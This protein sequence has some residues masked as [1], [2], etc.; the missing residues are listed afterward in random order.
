MSFNCVCH[1]EVVGEVWMLTCNCW[2]TL[3]G[4]E[5][6]E[7]LT[8]STN[9]KVL[10]LHIAFL[11]LE[12]ETRN[13][14]VGEAHN[15]CLTQYVWRKFLKRVVAFELMLVIHDIFHAFNEPRINLGEVIES[16]NCIAL[17][18]SLCNSEYTEV[19]WVCQFLVEVVEFDMIVT[20]KSVHSLTNHTETFLEHFLK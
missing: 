3:N 9:C 10:L 13:L 15:L 14:E 20:Y 12:H 6:A 2:D 7:L 1:V 11:N 4:R 8:L 19:G 16:L 17:L 18:K 5:N